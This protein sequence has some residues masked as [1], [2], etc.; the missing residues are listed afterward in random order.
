[1]TI[2]FLIVLFLSA[3]LVLE[4][5]SRKQAAKDNEVKFHPFYKSA[6]RDLNQYDFAAPVVELEPHEQ[7]LE[8]LDQ[9]RRR[10]EQVLNSFHVG[11]TTPATP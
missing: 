4:V 5:I 11:R 1:M 2:L 10:K 3:S 9:L 6:V 8:K 7:A